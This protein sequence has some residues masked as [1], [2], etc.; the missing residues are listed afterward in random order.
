MSVCHCP[1]SCTPLLK[2]V[3]KFILSRVYSYSVASATA[4]VRDSSAC[5]AGSRGAF[6]VLQ[7]TKSRVVGDPFLRLRSRVGEENSNTKR[8]TSVIETYIYTTLHANLRCYYRTTHLSLNEDKAIWWLPKKE[9]I[10][11]PYIGTT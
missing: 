10:L 9:K 6:L 8:R 11:W 3:S 2:F 1:G 5:W 4:I 7:I